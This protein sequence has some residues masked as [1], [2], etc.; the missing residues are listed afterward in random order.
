MK[1]LDA[2]GRELSVGNAVSCEQSAGSFEATVTQIVFPQ[3]LF[4]P[5]VVISG[6]DF[7]HL[8]AF[9]VRAEQPDAHRCPS[10]TLI[11]SKEPDQQAVSTGCQKGEQSK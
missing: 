7:A 4:L 5:Y 1:I 11:D 8:R 10:L 2:E 3:M 6:K 9:T